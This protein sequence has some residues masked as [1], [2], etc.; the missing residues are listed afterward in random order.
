MLLRY[1]AGIIEVGT[2]LNLLGVQGEYQ[3]Y[4]NSSRQNYQL[5]W[6]AATCTIQ[7]VHNVIIMMQAVEALSGNNVCI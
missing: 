5:N 2:Y 6:F 7:H 1:L 3:R 4:K